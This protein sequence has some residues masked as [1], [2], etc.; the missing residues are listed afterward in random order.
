MRRGSRLSWSLLFVLVLVLTAILV[1]PGIAGAAGQSSKPK[2]VKEL[3]DL[4]TADS[5]TYLL[6]NGAR[7]LEIY[8]VPIHFKDAKGNWQE[9]D[10][11]LVPT[12][13]GGLASKATPAKVKLS[14]KDKGAPIVSLDYQ[15]S[16]LELSMNDHDFAAPAVKGG[17]ASYAE[18]SPTA[19]SGVGQ[20]TSTSAIPLQPLSSPS[21]ATEILG[22][23][24]K[25]AALTTE[26]LPTTSTS[27]APKDTTPA[28]TA[29]S[30]T[31]SDTTPSTLESTT[32]TAPASDSEMTLSYQVTSNGVKEDI[33]LAS[34]DAPATY[35]F[36]V[37][38]PGLICKKDKTGQWGF[39]DTEENP[40]PLF[41]LG[42]I[43]VYDSSQGP[44]GDPAYCDTAVMSVVPG[45]DESTVT[46]T[47]PAAWL[48]DPARLF[49][50]T[51][52]P[53]VTLGSTNADTYIKQGTP[54]S[55]FG[56]SYQDPIGYPDTSNKWCTGLF[57]FTLPTDLTSGGYV[58][59]AHFR[60]YQYQQTPSGVA[61]V[62]R[63]SA[64][65]QTWSESSTYNSLG[66]H[67]WFGSD[68][69]SVA[70]T[71]AQAQWLDFDFTSTV[72]Q[73]ANG[74]RPNYG[75]T[76]Y[77]SM[78]DYNQSP[79]WWRRVL[80]S[81]YD[82]QYNPDPNY[83]PQL[84]I[85]YTAPISVATYGATGT[86]VPTGPNYSDDTTAFQRAI[87][88]VDTNGG[89][90]TVPAGTYYL[91]G[92]SLTHSNV[93]FRGA[94]TSSIILPNPNP[95]PTLP[96]GQM[97]QIGGTSAVSN[98]T[99]Q[100]LYMRVP[101]G[102]YGVRISG[103]G[104]GSGI[105]VSGLALAGGGDSADT[106]ALNVG[107]GFTGL[108]VQNNDLTSVSAVPVKVSVG[109]A[110][111]SVSGNFGPY[112]PYRADFY[113]GTDQYD[114]AIRLSKARF[115]QGAPA[116]V[117]VPGDTW[118]EAMTASPLAHAYGGP[119]LYTQSSGVDSRTLAE[120]Q[121]LGPTTVFVIGLSTTITS[122]LADALPAATVTRIAGSDIYGTAAA[123]AT[124]VKTKLG[125]VS[126]AVLV[127]SDYWDTGIATG[128]I[129]GYN[130]FPVL[131]TPRNGPVPTTTVN[132]IKTTLGL[133][134]AGACGINPSVT[135][136][137][138]TI[139]YEN[140][141]SPNL[142]DPY[143]IAVRFSDDY[144]YEAPGQEPQANQGLATAS[145]YSDALALGAYL[146]VRNGAIYLTN[147]DT[148]PPDTDWLLR[149]AYP[150]RNSLTYVG[151]PNL[152]AD[153]E[154]AGAWQPIAPRHTTYDFDS[155]ADHQVSAG[156][157]KAAL[158]LS[159]TDLAVA[160]FGPQ[161]ALTRTY[162]SG[163]T[164]SRYFAPGWVFSFD[165][166]LVTQGY[167]G[168]HDR[169]TDY[170]DES[171]DTYTFCEDA[172]NWIAP[173]GFT[174]TLR[175]GEPTTPGYYTNYLL[176]LPSGNTLTFDQTGELLS[177]AD[178]NG[179][180]V[181]YTWGGSS[182][183][184]QAANGQQIVVTLNG[185]QVT[186]ASYQT[187][188]GTRTVTYA[189]AAPWTV[190]YSY[191][192]TP[193]TASHSLTYGYTGSLVT[194][195]TAT[196]FTNGQD[197]TENYS[198]DGNGKLTG[199]TFPDHGTNADAHA[200][201]DNGSG[202][203]TVH[204]WG[205]VYTSGSSTG[206]TGTEV[207]QA[208]TW[209]S[210]GAML[211]K[212]NPKTSGDST[213]TWTYTYSLH[214]NWLLSELSPLNKT[215]SWT[216]N[217]H[218]N[219]TSETNELSY[220]TTYAYPDKDS[221]VQGKKIASI[222]TSADDGYDAGT[223]L[224]TTDY[225]YIAIG[226]G[227]AVDKAGWRFQNLDIPQ[228]ATITDV[229]FRV[230]AYYDVNG[231]VT[232]L[233][234]Q[235]GVEDT[236]NSIAWAAGGHEPRTAALTSAYINWQPTN[237]YGQ[238]EWLAGNWYTC[239]SSD[240][241][242]ADPGL[243]NA[244][245][246]VVDRGGW[247]SGNAL[248]VLWL[249]NGT[250]AT[251]LLDAGDYK[252][253]TPASLTISYYTPNVAPDPTRDEAEAVTGEDPAVDGQTA[254]YYDPKGNE[255]R[256]TKQ[257][258]ATQA[259]D[260]TSGLADQSA[261]TG[262][263]DHGASVQSAELAADNSLASPSAFD[264]SA[265]T[266]Y[267][268][269]VFADLM[270]N[271]IDGAMTGDKIA[272]DNSTG[273]HYVS[274]PISAA[275]L[276]QR[277]VYRFSAYVKA[278]GDTQVGIL[279]S[280]ANGAFTQSQ[281]VF[282][283]AN[284]RVLT[285][286]TCE[287]AG[288]SAVDGGWY[289]IWADQPAA[290]SASG[291]VWL[292]AASSGNL[293]YAGAG[294][295]TVVST[296]PGFYAV[297]AYAGE[298]VATDSS[299]QAFALNGEPTTT[300]YRGV[301]LQDGGQ[302]TDLTVSQT[303][304]NFGNL[305][306]KTDTANQAAETETYDLAGRL[307]TSTGPYF[308][309]TVG[310]A[311]STQIVTHH[312]YDAWG[313]ET[314]S[315]Q[316]STGET[317]Q[318]KADWTATTYDAYGRTSQV[319][320]KLSPSGSV[321]STVTSTYDGMGRLI[322]SADTTVS[323]LAAWTSYDARGNVVYSWAGGACSGSYDTAKATQH[324]TGTTPAYD[325]LNHVLST[326]NPGDTNSTTFTYT[327]DGRVL[328]ETK[329]DGSWTENTYDDVGNVIHTKTSVSS[330]SYLTTTVYDENGRKTS[331]TDANNLTTTYAYDR[332]GNVSS[333]GTGA[334][335]SQ[336][337]TDAQGWQI[338][339]QDADG[340]T[341]T[342]VFDS[343]GRV[344]SETSAGYTTTSTYQTG[345]PG[346]QIGLLSQ[347]TEGASDRVATYSYDWF[348]RTNSDVE[349]AGGT[350]VKNTSTTYDSLGRLS[351]ST[352]NTRNL[353]HFFTYPQNTA[354]ST[355]DA[356]GV[357]ASG[358]DL[359]TTTLTIG[360]DGYET[361]RSSVITSNPQVPNLTRTISPRDNAER[362]TNATLAAGQGNAYSQYS[363]DSAGRLKRQWGTTGGGSGYTSGAQSNDAY[364]YDATSGLKTSDNVQLTSVGTSGPATGTYTYETSG[365]ERLASAATNG[366]ASE[367]Y[368]YDAAGN[369]QT[370][371][372]TTFYY[373][374][375]GNLL[376]HSTGGYARYYFF[377]PTGK[378][379]TVQAPTNNQNDPNRETFAYTGTGRLQ[380]YTKYVSGTAS[381]T[382][383]YTYDAQGQR[384]KSVVAIT[385]GL[386]TTTNFN[387]EGL[388]LMS[389]AASQAGTGNPTSWKITYLYD[390]NGKPY[391]GIYRNP[392]TSTAPVV[393]TMVTT[394]R[395]DVVELLDAAGN[396]FVAY[397]Y[398]AW[399]NPQDRYQ[400]PGNVA[401][402]IYSQT[403][404]LITNSQVATDIANRQVLR[405]ARYCYD[406]ESGLY[407][408]SARS[409]D[410]TTRQ[411]LSKDL[412]RADGE[413]SAYEYCTGNPV[414]HVDPSGLWCSGWVDPAH[415]YNSK[416]GGQESK[417]G[418]TYTYH[419]G[420]HIN[421]WQIGLTI[422]WVWNMSQQK[423][424][425]IHVAHPQKILA[426]GIGWSYGGIV[427]SDTQGGVGDTYAYY[428]YQAE[429][430]FLGGTAYAITHKYPALWFTCDYTGSIIG[431]DSN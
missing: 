49:P 353:T 246:T 338:K 400:A 398:D 31:T 62:A 41:A 43:E 230:Y 327:D 232:N 280:S 206:A 117:V 66:A 333:A 191:T 65:T 105:T 234:T 431:Y 362:V 406:S 325:A 346:G 166:R 2:V 412:A 355:T 415:S 345:L 367:S 284:D 293:S 81:N 229:Q 213:Q 37:K 389:L 29:S 40:Y 307:F 350:T 82:A 261:G 128:A 63:A 264:A 83:Y 23:L 356:Y 347:K 374:G 170:I 172:G 188:N 309:A 271:P 125:S 237:A 180:T 348:G 11:S 124:Q 106:Q 315:W 426:G 340:F 79:R 227:T 137:G 132:E 393:F 289:L 364:T 316:T 317:A 126:N 143:Q 250:A 390:E 148:L 281:A 396:P 33:V 335:T 57:K 218:G 167:G 403:T 160:S 64:M 129:A 413:E 391:A 424:K 404:T 95:H 254:N 256:V 193:T 408:L 74:S 370:A 181:T 102:G 190:T 263:T 244:V 253:G 121:R 156:L 376:D 239:D 313:H 331:D 164:A 58:Q 428:Y 343:A 149:N 7:Q 219:V 308:T 30:T 334:G 427:D 429:Y 329:P 68:T 344:T 292:V 298:E 76:L 236:D 382:G 134:T 113:Q 242:S 394:D 410:P 165:R 248:S 365:S 339:I 120:L 32:T 295:S 178:A 233:N 311:T 240:A 48:A 46:Y 305:L 70:T 18:A 192:G 77:Q 144:L 336:F 183:T 416:Y 420:V 351:T 386:T 136:S 21:T 397:H 24:D 221:V 195:L 4:R 320:K 59:S 363:Y 138:V 385:G 109:G 323:G 212:T 108:N 199:V 378:W 251:N 422:D 139:T 342:R 205:R 381:V 44:S 268:T 50:V 174:G 85:T 352:D 361:S 130:E 88:A 196:A 282:D 321:Q 103:S 5:K 187:A 19:A 34:T 110:G 26:T 182:L 387:Y 276:T 285:G 89:V 392:G 142:Y 337:T 150:T 169:T 84:V 127:C 176:T 354:A 425:Y 202:T 283:L 300:I 223:T 417:W 158:N 56:S 162:S 215:R 28:D 238:P 67:T 107:S 91:S 267:H 179:N 373:Q 197:A 270:D 245:Q 97:I 260:T 297:S 288:I 294:H 401:T 115:P 131:F 241:P 409:Y 306:T 275:A 290:A 140:G 203:A 145:N 247:N 399:G 330:P 87:D 200:T 153:D 358:A 303:F 78:S 407:Y 259:A 13:D 133:N 328:R 324:L 90:V 155:F 375:G 322:S 147:D 249:D 25:L 154:N 319:Q 72:Q 118:Q 216:F 186:G 272:E 141:D 222:A 224:H 8:A 274:Q 152:W 171:G 228:G 414:G 80:T 332:D 93:I 198:Y 204:R 173:P 278:G 310:S 14:K 359:A 299:T 372:S 369:I 279:F 423:I 10:T 430:D 9:I 266:K 257:L 17:T 395:G 402:G 357:G 151:R 96:I 45:T 377:D 217:N 220:T 12:S 243:K 252:N 38:H 157:D 318:T 189:T 255:P 405:Y 326:T 35:S 101:Q 209:N 211:T 22:P 258:N 302:P 47:I 55:S 185:G 225:N 194:G 419:N 42:N 304:D 86:N 114:T 168:F 177:E 71:S 111:V 119:M 360:A 73:W 51:I 418:F 287:A 277:K 421:C 92:L 312:S 16:T 94:G 210:A 99:V 112:Q 265:W 388:N 52:D 163:S 379:R 301:V 122:A 380:T 262:I 384:S 1:I 159:T 368:T 53:T 291:V 146:A 349:T 269:G 36:T 314:E 286:K 135:I 69:R 161:A 20:T 214:T 54:D 411:F 6:S 226:H 3:T 383:T 104:G 231:S 201:I 175:G 208:F 75:F 371:G 116:A 341:T 366:N 184:M 15:G 60:V 27:Q 39:Y 100:D 296:D 123:V 98:V 273:Y 61:E 235:L 207:T